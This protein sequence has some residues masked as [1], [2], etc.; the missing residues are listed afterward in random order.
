MPEMPL[1]VSDSATYLDYL[2][3][4]PLDL[5][6]WFNLQVWYHLYLIGL[7]HSSEQGM[8]HST[9]DEV[10]F[11]PHSD[12]LRQPRKQ[13]SPHKTSSTSLHFSYQPLTESKLTLYLLYT[14]P[15]I[16]TVDKKKAHTFFNPGGY[17]WMTICTN[18]MTMNVNTQVKLWYS[19]W[20]LWFYHFKN[21]PNIFYYLVLIWKMIVIMPRPL[22]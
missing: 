21:Y 8:I 7:V 4:S 14:L 9:L 10:Y 5:I 11:I 1:W 15:P 12:S 22:I 13:S 2:I 16:Q 6:P 19:T 18:L 20:F 3:K 17:S